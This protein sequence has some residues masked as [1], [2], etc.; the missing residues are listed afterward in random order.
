[1]NSAAYLWIGPGRLT[2][3]K[4]CIA[5]TSWGLAPSP[6]QA[7]YIVR[8]M[9][10]C[11]RVCAP[12]LGDG[13][14]GRIARCERARLQSAQLR[15]GNEV[16]ARA[17]GGLIVC[18]CIMVDATRPRGGPV[19]VL[20]IEK[21]CASR[22]DPYAHCHACISIPTIPL[23][24]LYARGTYM[25]L[26]YD[27][28]PSSLTFPPKQSAH[29]PKRT[30]SEVIVGGAVQHRTASEDPPGSPLDRRHRSA[31]LGAHR[32]VLQSSEGEK[33]RSE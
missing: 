22:C 30:Q 13:I 14:P 32:P 19:Q 11:F 26:S 31:T 1:M 3:R 28:V 7:L 5:T 33:V 18:I 29:Q 8:V 2:F 6:A 25:T 4:T 12:R 24:V 16:S 17:A 10:C 27:V 15:P 21:R 23:R 20:S 9:R